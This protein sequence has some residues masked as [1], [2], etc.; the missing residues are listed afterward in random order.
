MAH[1]LLGELADVQIGYQ[2]SGRVGREVDGTHLLVQTADLS[3]A[4]PIDWDRLPSI[5]PRRRDVTRQELIDGDVLFLAKGTRRVAAVVRRPP[6][7]C[8]AVSTIYV[9]RSRD[10]AVLWPEYLAW[11]LN[12]AARDALAAREL[13]GSSMPFVRKEGL[14]DLPL[15]VPS[16]ERQQTVAHL[17]HLL[18]RERMLTAALLDHRER[19]INT[20]AQRAA[21]PEEA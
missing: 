17:D 1:V 4:G 16:L 20:L 2:V 11:F 10:H 9:V 8:L 12:V 18:R 21:G 13:Q 15:D 19:L 7:R 3:L 6:A 5:V 14:L